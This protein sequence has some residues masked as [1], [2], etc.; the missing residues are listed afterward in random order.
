MG[1]KHPRVNP[2]KQKRSAPAPVF[3]R[4]RGR[5]EKCDS[6]ACLLVA[7]IATVAAQ[8]AHVLARLAAISGRVAL[9]AL[10]LARVL[11]ELVAG[12]RGPRAVTGGML[13]RDYVAIVPDLPLVADDLAVVGADVA[14]I[15]PHFVAVLPDVGGRMCSLRRGSGGGA[16][17]DGGAEQEGL[18]RGHGE[19]PPRHGNGSRESDFDAGPSRRSR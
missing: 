14:A 2:K 9:V 1:D 13:L 11:P 12:R 15:R 18:E 17:D 4:A 8:V 7:L 19:T 3:V 10:Q 5:F 6:A 16:E